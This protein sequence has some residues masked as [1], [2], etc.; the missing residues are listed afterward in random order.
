[1]LLVRLGIL[2]YTDIIPLLNRY[3]LDWSFRFRAIHLFGVE[4]KTIVSMVFKLK[5]TDIIGGRIDVNNLRVRYRDIDV[6]QTNREAYDE[7]RNG[8]V[9]EYI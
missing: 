1:M 4:W 6:E 7:Y 8:D 2:I 9:I 3:L 5:I